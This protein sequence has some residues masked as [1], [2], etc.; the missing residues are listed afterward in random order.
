MPWRKFII[1]WSKLVSVFQ[2]KC[3][4]P[5]TSGSRREIN[6]W[7]LHCLYFNFVVAH[8]SFIFRTQIFLLTSDLMYTSLSDQPHPSLQLTGDKRQGILNGTLG[9][10]VPALVQPRYVM[11]DTNLKSLLHPIA[12]LDIVD[13]NRVMSRNRK[14]VQKKQFRYYRYFSA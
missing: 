14:L 2:C 12:P 6:I 8:A 1:L 3:Y 13:S 7:P 9:Q 4:I 10:W 11:K 5:D